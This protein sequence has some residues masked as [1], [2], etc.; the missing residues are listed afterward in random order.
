MISCVLWSGCGFTR[1]RRRDPQHVA[2]RFGDYLDVHPVTMNSAADGL[3]AGW[4]AQNA[5]ASRQPSFNSGPV[6][7]H[8]MSTPAVL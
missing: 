3:I 7:R 8:D 5:A 2:R 4:A 6:V 1:R